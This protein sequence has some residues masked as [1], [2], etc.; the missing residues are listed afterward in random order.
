MQS[1]TPQHVSSLDQAIGVVRE[2]LARHPERDNVAAVAAVMKGERR[3]YPAITII[4]LSYPDDK[5][6]APPGSLLPE[7]HTPDTPDGRLARKVVGLLGPLNLHNPVDRSLGLGRGTGTLVP[8]FGIPLD[9]E[10]QDAPAFTRTLDDVLRDDPPDPRSS[11]LMP[12]MHERIDFLKD[13]LPPFFNIGMPDVQ[14]PYN[15]AHAVLGQEALTAPYLEPRKF[16]VFMERVTT[17]WIEAFKALLVW[18]GPEY[19]H[20]AD[21]VPMVRECSVNLVS[22]ECYREHI[23][24]HDRRLGEAL[25][26]LHIHPCS[27]PHVFHATLENLPVRVTEAGWIERT[28]AGAIRVDEALRAIEDRPI[29]L[30]IGQELPPGE[31]EEFIRA[32]LDRYADHPGLLFA[33]TG[34][35]WRRKDRPRI[36]EMHRRLDA[37]WAARYGN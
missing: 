32:D 13:H 31:E 3:R 8:C 30:R 20:P 1:D 25:G 15:I 27:G 33:Y 34:M 5:T 11:G 10:A 35:Y 37:Y 6:D 29:A 19:L 9:P 18:I 17:L 2:T 14:G 23:L 4:H 7:V 12:Q 22:T 26:P 36:R 24:P 21:E 28:A 16:A